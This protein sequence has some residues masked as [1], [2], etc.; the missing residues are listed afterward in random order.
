MRESEKHEIKVQMLLDEAQDV[1]AD[2]RQVWTYGVPI[3]Q[4]DLFML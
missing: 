4:K 1:S 2:V 3:L